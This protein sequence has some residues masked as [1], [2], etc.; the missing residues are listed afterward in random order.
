MENQQRKVFVGVDFSPESE[1]AAR[2]A[3][4]ICR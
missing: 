4:D 2:Q 1:I 3:L